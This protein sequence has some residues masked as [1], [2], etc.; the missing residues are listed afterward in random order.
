MPHLGESLENFVVSSVFVVDG[1]VCRSDGDHV[2][3]IPVFVF[4]MSCFGDGFFYTCTDCVV[5]PSTGDWSR[6][7]CSFRLFCFFRLKGVI[8][9]EVLK[10]FCCGLASA[11]HG[12]VVLA[13]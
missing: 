6:L 1:V 7:V 4:D 2:V 9:V 12:F 5:E 8:T 11:E 10:F 3:T 13:L